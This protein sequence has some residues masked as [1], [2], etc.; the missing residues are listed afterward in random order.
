MGRKPKSTLT[1]AK[2]LKL[3][4]TTDLTQKR[5]LADHNANQN[6]IYRYRHSDPEFKSKMDLIKGK[7]TDRRRSLQDIYNKRRHEV[8]E[9]ADNDDPKSLFLEHFLRNHERV[10]ACDF[11]GVSIKRFLGWVDEEDET[12]DEWFHAAVQEIEARH[13]LAIEDRAIEQALGQ[14]QSAATMQRFLLPT[15]P[16]IG[17]K[18]AQKKEKSQQQL[19]VFGKDGVAEAMDVMKRMYGSKDIPSENA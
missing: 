14:G 16:I 2:F 18:Y 15:L 7:R 9:V 10:A 13:A 19:F 4:E 8:G 5:I 17:G 1:K 11:A 12:Y 3:L 6:Q